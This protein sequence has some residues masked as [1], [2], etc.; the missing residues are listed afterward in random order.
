MSLPTLTEHSAAAYAA[1]TDSASAWNALSSASKSAVM[2][3]HR[4][5]L[6]YLAGGEGRAAGTIYEASPGDPPPV[7]PSP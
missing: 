5:T 2:A 7:Q 4:F 1:A 3:R 6:D